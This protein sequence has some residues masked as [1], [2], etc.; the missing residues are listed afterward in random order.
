MG[1][2]IVEL[3]VFK[4]HNEKLKKAQ[5]DQHEINE[6]LL[7]IITTKKSPRNNEMEEEFSKNSS[8]NSSHETKREDNSSEETH[9]TKNKA[10]T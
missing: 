1:N 8:K 10:S 5:E 2:L 4:V 6:M 9:M 3:E 7:H